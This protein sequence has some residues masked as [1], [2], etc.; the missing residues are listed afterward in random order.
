MKRQVCLH[1]ANRPLNRWSVNGPHLNPLKCTLAIIGSYYTLVHSHLIV[2]AIKIVEFECISAHFN[3]L[4]HSPRYGLG[5]QNCGRMNYI[6]E[7]TH[8]TIIKHC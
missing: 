2:T 5:T 3:Q 7:A 8:F 1:F 6:L 4:K